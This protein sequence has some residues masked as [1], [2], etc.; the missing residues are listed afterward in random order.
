MISHCC[1]WSMML[2]GIIWKLM[3]DKK[4]IIAHVGDQGIAAS[5]PDPVIEPLSDFELP[6]FNSIHH[7]TWES[8]KNPIDDE[9]L[10]FDR[11]E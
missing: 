5:T 9:Q 10:D 4:T 11:F 3:K 2:K 6:F 7:Y 8:K 1:S